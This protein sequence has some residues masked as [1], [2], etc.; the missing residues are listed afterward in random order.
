MCYKTRPWNHSHRAPA[1]A[2]E[3]GGPVA[4]A[5]LATLVSIGCGGP[6]TPIA[7]LQFSAKVY[8]PSPYTIGKAVALTLPAAK[9][10]TGALTYSLSPECRGWNSTLADAR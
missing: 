7:P 5:A 3:P 8:D 9:G 6:I 1:R 2:A 10:G 4:L